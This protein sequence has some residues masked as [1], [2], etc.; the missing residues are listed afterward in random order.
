MGSWFWNASFARASLT[1]VT[2]GAPA[3]SASVK[4]RPRFSW[5]PSVWKYYGV[6]TVKSA[7]GA[8]TPV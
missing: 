4:S 3:V 5:T 1:I 6:T 8:R 2:S 7:C